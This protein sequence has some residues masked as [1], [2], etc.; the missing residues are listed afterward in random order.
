MKRAIIISMLLLELFV[1]TGCSELMRNR[2]EIDRI[3]NTRIIGIDKLEE[4]KILYTITTKAAASSAQEQGE[5]AKVSEVLVT[6]GTTV[7]EAA[8]NMLQYAHKRPH[9][10]HTEFI[11][12]GEDTAKAGI[13][14]YL[15]FISRNLEFRYN[16]KIYIIRGQTANEFIGK[17]NSGN[18]YLADKL[19]IMEDNAY[20]LS[21]SSKVTLNEALFIL[22]K[23]NV[24][25]FFPTLNIT[26][27]KIN[28]SP[29]EGNFDLLLKDYAIFKKDKLQDYL[30]PDLTRGVNWITNRIQ[31]GIILVEA[32]DRKKVSLEILQNKTSI[33]PYIDENGLQ[34]TINIKFNSNI[35]ESLSAEKIFTQ[36]A[37]NYLEQQQ[38]AEVKK[39]VEKT[40][41]HAQEKNLDFFGIATKFIIKYPMMKNELTENWNELFPDIKFKVEVDS[42]INRTYLIKEA[43]TSK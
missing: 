18:L 27:V 31:S 32:P 41:R 43:A 19:T 36:E 30:E 23:E 2:S 25:T 16:A 11:L 35:A 22:S 29:S 42:N 7:F 10:G 13:L 33:K 15:Y 24:S 14:P 26:S 39:E 1:F 4:N 28:E 6:E 34:C 20:A 38:E 17:L 37:M 12:F 3:F 21:Q 9:Y 40:L 8:R 5:G